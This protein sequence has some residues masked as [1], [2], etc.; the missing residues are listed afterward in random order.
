MELRHARFVVE[1]LHSKLKDG[2]I[3]EGEGLIDVINAMM[4]MLHD[5]VQAAEKGNVNYNDSRP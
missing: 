1:T 5:V 4:S 2:Y 3:C